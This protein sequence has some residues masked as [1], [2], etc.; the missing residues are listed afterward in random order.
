TTVGFTSSGGTPSGIS[1]TTSYQVGDGTSASDF[2]SC[3]GS[4]PNYSITFANGIVTISAQVLTLTADNQTYAYG[5][6][7]NTMVFFTISGAPT[8]AIIPKTSL[9]VGDGTSASD[10]T[11]CSGSDP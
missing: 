3:S 8:S 6:P 5:D 9:Q 2:T 10:F 7:V 4:D 1:C 11:S